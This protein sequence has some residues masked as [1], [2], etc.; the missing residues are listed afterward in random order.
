MS[1]HQ[2]LWLDDNERPAPAPM[3]DEQRVKALE[4]EL[5]QARKDLSEVR[6]DLAAKVKRALR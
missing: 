6:K 5:Q 4:Q 1:D 3:S 2:L